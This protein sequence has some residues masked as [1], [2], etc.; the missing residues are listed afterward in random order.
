MRLSAA[1][2]IVES[3]QRAEGRK[4]ALFAMTAMSLALMAALALALL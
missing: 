3:K 4:N 1:H 2:R